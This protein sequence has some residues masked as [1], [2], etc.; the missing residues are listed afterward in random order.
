MSDCTQMKIFAQDD[1]QNR[2]Q[3]KDDAYHEPESECFAENQCANRYSS[4]RFQGSYNGCWSSPYFVDSYCHKDKGKNCRNQPQP[5]G[6]EPGT[7][8]WWQLQVLFW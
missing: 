6:I 8:R 2:R 7:W 4:Q 5:T 1:K 3:N